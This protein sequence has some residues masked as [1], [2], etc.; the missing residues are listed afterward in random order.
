MARVNIEVFS[1]NGD[2]LYWISPAKA[3]ALAVMGAAVWISQGWGRRCLRLTVDSCRRSDSS[4]TPRDMEVVAG[5][6]GTR[7]EERAVRRRV[8]AWSPK[9]ART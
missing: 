6:V 1:S 2:S 7:E 9:E 5:L 4:L 8:E 3:H